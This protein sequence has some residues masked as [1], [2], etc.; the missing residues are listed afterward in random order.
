MTQIPDAQ[1]TIANL[2]D[3]HHEAN[4]EPPRPHFGASIAGHHCDRWIWLS[5]RWAVQ[6]KFPGRILRLFRRGQLEEDQII[7]DLK[8]I[9][10]T[11]RDEQKRVKLTGHVSGSIDGIAEGVP[12]APKTEHLLE[13]KTHSA[14]SFKDLTA[15]GVEASKPQH[16]A[17]MQL[18]MHGLSL[19]RALYIAVCKDDDHIYTERVRYDEAAAKAILE[20]AKRISLADRIPDPI[21]TDPSW[22]LCKF[23]A[24]HSFCHKQEPTQHVNCRTCAHAT[25]KPGGTWRCERHEADGIPNEFQRQGCDDHVL[26]PDVVPWQIKDSNDP[27]EAVYIING[28]EIRNGHPDGYTFGSKELL[29]ISEVKTAF[30]GAKIS[31]V[32]DA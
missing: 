21:S 18:Y 20:R 6:E 5:F 26:H 3:A 14:K 1:N 23:C 22:Y 31:Q 27:H 10:I 32:R 29:T 11:V 16:Y 2:I 15:K 13:F 19:T 4:Q 25:A 28:E 17:Q 30:P 12:G 8:A 7:S 24:A 9:G